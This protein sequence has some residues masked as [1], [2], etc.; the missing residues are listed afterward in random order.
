[1][2]HRTA[3]QQKTAENNAV[4][5]SAA[6]NSAALNSASQNSL[7]QNSTA[8]VCS[9]EN[10]AVQLSAA[11]NSAA[12]N[13][14]AQNSA[15]Q[16]SAQWILLQSIFS[17][18]KNSNKLFLFR[19][20]VALGVPRCILVSI[21]VLSGLESISVCKFWQLGVLGHRSL[22][23]CKLVFLGVLKGSFLSASV[24]LCFPIFPGRLS[25]FR[26]LRFF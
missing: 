2:L 15:L 5:L 16:C 19:F 21:G 10:N 13:S 26:C 3:E 4:Q 24:V 9:A 12:L 23:R 7:A 22:S 17:S 11:Q 14:A 8:Y 25:A 18:G 20:Q 1:M 6:Q